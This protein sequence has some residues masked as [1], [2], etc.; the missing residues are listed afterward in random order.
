MV[1]TAPRLIVI[2]AKPEMAK[3]RGIQ[4][5][6]RVAAYCRVSTNDE[7][8]LTS[9][10][11]QQTY[12]TDKIMTNPAWTMAG[13]FADEGITGTSAKKRPEFL[14]MIRKCKQKKIDLILVKSISRFARNTLDCLNYTRA[15]REL[16]IAVFFEKENINTLEM[17]SEMLITIMGAFSQAES[18]SISENVK[19][20]IRQSMREGR[21]NIRYHSLYAYE[22][23]DDNKPK[24]IPEQAEVVRRIY[25]SFL[26][27]HSLRMIKTDLE[28][29]RI[30]A[31]TGGNEW[32]ISVLRGIL[33]N[34]KYCG[35]VLMQK[36]FI[37]DCIS[38][39]H[40][41]NTG[42]L[43]MYLLQNH[44][45]GIV[46]RDTFN[47]VQ[48]ELARR[49][50]EKAPSKKQAPTGQARYSAKY[51]LT[52]VVVCGDCGT[53]Y[54]RC[55]W[56]KQGKKRAV[57]R[58]ASRI[59]YGSRY[60][61]ESPTIYEKPLQRAIL[62][63]IN[64]VMSQKSVLIERIT[65]AIRMEILPLTGDTMSISDIEQR[66]AQLEAEFQELFQRSRS[67]E[68]G[69]MKYADDFS[70]I[71]NEMSELKEQQNLLL[72]REQ[73]DSVASRKISD[74][75]NILNV[76]SN[77]I[78]EWDESMIRQM[79]DEVRVLSEDRII[80]RLRGGM[81]VEKVLDEERD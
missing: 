79:V 16:G 41:K 3:S 57:W 29:E 67:A 53:L 34:E 21:A 39:K 10:E 31:V 72:Q 6:L 75:V 52:G 76:G 64:S 43:P 65:D 2:P 33:T 47:A 61:K 7:E 45:E 36:S 74:A 32:S 19:W 28:S 73:N 49:R 35:D 26:S 78:S 50:A 14:R 68:G 51:A 11:A 69:Y 54:Q 12:Y 44:H 62:S 13:I 56:S 17:D 1:E 63:A 37:N 40:I 27:G 18:E 46:S 20:G 30:P 48:T 81:E 55:V 66:I 80:V 25:D 5:Q 38:K 77:E 60:C 71:N 9:Y 22:R 70:R 42:Q 23:G 15:L 4:R 59:D 24:I 58:C 8:Q